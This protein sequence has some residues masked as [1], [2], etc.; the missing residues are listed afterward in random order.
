MRVIQLTR[1][2]DD[3]P[4]YVDADQIV[5]MRTLES[6]PPGAPQTLVYTDA[7]SDLVMESLNRAVALWKGP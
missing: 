7:G 6:S 5:M 2:S 1:V 4:L 3:M